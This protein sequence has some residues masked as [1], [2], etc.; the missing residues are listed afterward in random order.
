[1]KF[2]I[3]ECVKRKLKLHGTVGQ[4]IRQVNKQVS[5]EIEVQM[6]WKF[7]RQ[8]KPFLNKI[9]KEIDR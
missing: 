3:T 7:N 9:H 4:W 6:S 1:M 8:F 2:T 5:R